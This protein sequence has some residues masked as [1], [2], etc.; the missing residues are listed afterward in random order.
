M[1]NYYLNDDGSTSTKIK[2]KGTN[3]I[4]QDDGSTITSNPVI[5]K[6]KKKKEQEDKNFFDKATNVGKVAL[7][8]AGNLATNMAEG[9]LKTVE[10]AYDTINSW[11]DTINNG[12]YEKVSV[13]LGL[14]T[15]EEAKKKREKSKKKTQEFIKRDLTNEFMDKTGFNDIKEDW[16]RDSLIKSGNIG[17]QVTKAI[18]G[19]VPSLVVGGATGKALGGADTLASTST[20]GLSFGKKVLTTGKNIGKAAL[21]SLGANTVLGT[22]SYGS[23]LEEAYQN[24]ATDDEAKKYA[25]GSSATE[26]ATE[27]ITGGIPGIKS[28][29]FVD[30]AANKLIDKATGKAK[31]EL[32]KGITKTILN[33]GYEV[34]GE[35]LEEGISE[36]ISPILKNAT[37]SKDEKI[38]WNDVFQSAI[39]GGITGGILNVPNT[40]IDLKNNIAESKNTIN[41]NQQATLPTGLNNSLN[42]NYQNEQK[43]ETNPLMNNNHTMLPVD[44]NTYQKINNQNINIE[45]QGNNV[46]ISNQNNIGNILDNQNVNNNFEYIKSD[47]S[48]IDNLRESANEYLNNSNTSKSFIETAEKVITDKGYNILLDNTLT[49]DNGNFV[50]AQ[51]KTLDNGEVEI[52]INPNSERAGEFL[53]T[54]EITHAIEQQDMV[55]LVMDYASKNQEFNDALESLKLTYGTNE[56]SSEVLADIS[57]QLFGNEEFI[58]TLSTQKPNIFKRLYNSIISLANKITGNSRESLFIKDLKNKWESAYRNNQNNLSNDTKYM[59]TGKIGMQNA[60]KTNSKNSWLKKNYDKAQQLFENNIRNEDV[61]QKTGWFVGKD[62]KQRFEISDEDAKLKNLNK[63]SKNKIEDILE[64]DDLFEMYPKLKKEKIVFKDIKPLFDKKTKKSYTT[65]G[66]FN[67]ITNTIEINNKL[68]ELENGNNLI[69]STL[70]HEIQHYIQKIENFQNGSSGKKGIEDYFGNLGEQEAKDTTKRMNMNYQERLNNIPASEK[71]TDIE[72]NKK[73]LYNVSKEKEI[74]LDEN[75]KLIENGLSEIYNE[76]K[77][78]SKL[79]DRGEK[80][81]VEENEIKTQKNE[82]SELERNEGLNNSSFSLDENAKRYE[83]LLESNSIKYYR[84][85]NG[86]VSVLLVDNKNNVVNEFNLWS[87]TQAVKE[88]GEKLGTRIYETATEKNQTIELTNDKNV[89]PDYFMSHRPTE[90]GITADNLIDQKVESPMPKDMYEHPEWYFQMNEKYSKESMSVLNKIRNNPDADIT[91]YRATTGNKINPGDWITLSKEYAKLHNEHSLQGKGN[92]VEMKVKAKDIQFAGDDIN[93]F[94]YFPNNDTKYSQQSNKWQE[95]LEENYKSNG[96]KSYFEDMRKTETK[97]TEQRVLDKKINKIQKQYETDKKKTKK[98]MTKEVSR[99]LEFSNYKAKEK[100]TDLVSEYYDNPDYNKIK[101]DIIDNFS[102]QKIEYVNEEIKEIKKNIRSTDLKIDDYI[103]K[104]ITDYAFFRK[105]NFNKLKLKNE[106]QSVDS[107]YNELSE[108]YPSVFSKDITNEVNQLKRLSEFMDEDGKVVEKYRIDDQAIEEATKYIYDSIKNKDSIDDLIDSISISPKE[109]RKEK[110]IQYREEAGSFIENSSDW[111]DKKS[112]LAYKTNTMKRNF[113]DV[114]GKE[115]ASRL[116]SNYI[117]PIFNHNAQMQKDIDT[118][119]KKI[120]DLNLNE[121]ESCAV[122]MLGEY[123]YNPETLVTGTQVDEFISSN[124]IDYKKIEKAVEVFRNTYDEL[125]E[126]VNTVLKSQGYKTIEYR[127]GYF[128]H[129]IENKPTGKIGKMMEKLGWKFKDNDIPTSIAGITDTFK[130][131]KVWTSFSQKRKGKITDYNALKGFDNY[132]RGAMQ[133]IYFTEDIQKLRALENEIRYQHSDKGIQEKIDEIQSDDSLN[134]DDKQDKIEKI[135]A[136]YI[137]PLNNFVSELRDYTNGIANKKSG[138]DRTVE[139]LSNR[140][141]YNVMENVSNR[142]SANMVGLNLSSAITNFIPITQATSQVK[143]KYL[144]KGLKEAIKNQYSNDNFESKSVF[145][146]SRLNEADKLYKTKLEKISDK[147]NFMFDGIDSITSNTIVRG[148]YYENIAKGMS[149]FNAIRNADEFARDLMA[150]R[151]KGEMPTAFNSKNPLIKMFTAFQL[152]VN[153]QFGYMFKD[154]PRDL[155]DEATS[156]LLGAFIKMFFGAWIYNQ[157]TEKVVGRKSAFSPGDTIKE[158]YDTA[159]NDNFTIKEKSSTILENLTQDIPFIGGLIG[160]GR[161][162]ISSVANPLNVLKGE[163]TVKDEA[164]KA[165]YYTVLPF[166]GGQLKKTVE[167]TSMYVNNKKIKG[168][169]TSKGQLRFE[170]NKEPLSVAQNVL[171]GQYSNKNAR[172][173][174][175]KGYMPLTEKQLQEV[176]KMNISVNKYRKYQDDKKEINKIKSDKDS[177]GKSING[178]AAGKKAY[179]IMNSNFSNKE[180]NYLLSK[181]SSSKNSVKVSDLENLPK[182][183]KIYKFYF[184]LNKDS[185][186]DFISELNTYNISANDLYDYYSTR[187]KIKDDYTPTYAKTK[188][189]EYIKTS[190]FDEK[191]KWYLY[192]K[193]YGSDSTKLIVNTFNLKT[194][195]YFNTMEYATKIKNMYP[196]EK[197]SKIRKQK[198][199]N[200]I[201]N[202]NLSQKEKIVL[203]SQAGYSTKAYKNSMYDY[204]NNLKL[205]K[206]EKEK[207][208]KSLY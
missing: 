19:M 8:T 35:G 126:R 89:E 67:P 203:F 48:K 26:L 207:I 72:N 60:I 150:G 182:D 17:G 147:A 144:I 57:G 138:L 5:K 33:S 125:F 168:S 156:K 90:S 120:K 183:K 184:G 82:N 146:T 84:Q 189:I 49:S 158:I 153:N 174:F 111:I 204:I 88:L 61:R 68:F 2:S 160:G 106:G 128:P 66:Q 175:D 139:S 131:G 205:T 123:K 176:E 16:E 30:K 46:N 193:D 52:R 179:L 177:D 132:I 196:H 70:L 24:G 149:E 198:V 133:D 100:F 6:K 197:Q 200:Y 13:A 134:F 97:T 53:L 96:T 157:F 169:Y 155:K 94:G 154:L 110:T 130:P 172:E 73:S 143:T 181:L 161:L 115:D 37:Y 36:I 190:K 103:K 124:K 145:L 173:Y 62:G 81:N 159:T 108:M 105:S 31:N 178:S 163:S 40:A 77:R 208:W 99:I 122:Q 140:K 75:N 87:N 121:N 137:T 64:H 9:A 22:S 93:E 164:K 109:I 51:I 201:N 165:L 42:N 118:Y 20:K 12:A 74:L 187:K 85:S 104:N 54:H 92:I 113:Y 65:A 162:P 180:K 95:H 1:A 63:N 23:A 107:F 69:K 171:F 58:N 136:T 7:K 186:K 194:N 21:P 148:K 206:R 166:G 98:F 191:T 116:Y 188:M 47:N 11:D 170:A 129:F 34:I 56:V 28:T 135:Y 27:W 10:G 43:T 3:Y 32:V 112:G 45:E 78:S 86:D 192:N 14:A 167:G 91:I 151:T 25:L 199:F 55:N 141:F 76:K 202:L 117:E 44:S 185:R 114:M 79:D 80:I 4:M 50:N 152:E 127:K 142:L 18:G 38:N 59:M 83:D 41:K 15:K 119:N 102:E 195:D 71:L 29:G 39:V 101:Q